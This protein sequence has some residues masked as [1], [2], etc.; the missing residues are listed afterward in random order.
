VRNTCH[1][2]LWH[3]GHWIPIAAGGGGGRGHSRSTRDTRSSA[4]PLLQLRPALFGDT[5]RDPPLKPEELCR[6]VAIQN[7]ATEELHPANGKIVFIRAR[8]IV[9]DTC[10]IQPAIRHE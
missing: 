7:R 5:I 6:G 4:I 8:P 1:S 10:Q 9:S 2:T 3:L